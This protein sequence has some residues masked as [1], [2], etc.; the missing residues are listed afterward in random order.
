MKLLLFVSL[1]SCWQHSDNQFPHT[2]L[3][4]RRKKGS[5][6]KALPWW[7]WSCS[8]WIEPHLL[9]PVRKGLCPNDK[10]VV[11]SHIFQVVKDVERPVRTFTWSRRTS[12]HCR[13]VRPSLVAPYSRIAHGFPAAD[14]GIYVQSAREKTLPVFQTVR[15]S[16]VWYFEKKWKLGLGT[17]TWVAPNHSTSRTWFEVWDFWSTL[18]CLCYTSAPAHGWQL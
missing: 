4:I 10:C 16:S 5:S 3:A 6:P 9:D 12:R 2:Y 17:R 13:I 8:F 1:I 15:Y 14:F 7:T 11:G 18:L